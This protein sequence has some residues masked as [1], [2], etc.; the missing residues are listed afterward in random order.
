[1]RILS[2]AALA[3]GSCVL[4]TDAG[5]RQVDNRIGRD[6]QYTFSNMDAHEGTP[7]DVVLVEK[8]QPPPIGPMDKLLRLRSHARIVLPPRSKTGAPY[9]DEVLTLRNAM[10]VPVAELLFYADTNNND[11][12][13]YGIANGSNPNGEHIWR[14]P[15][16]ESGIGEFAH[17][18]NFT[19]FQKSEYSLMLGNVVLQIDTPREWTPA[20]CPGGEDHTLEVRVVI[21]PGTE[22][23]EIGYYKN[24]GS[25]PTPST[26]IV[27]ED[28]VDA[29][30]EY[31][32]DV[33]IDGAVARAIKVLA[34][35]AGNL[36]IAQGVW[37]PA[38]SE[39]K[40]TVCK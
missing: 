40:A 21:S 15:V 9:P 1:M 14:E 28:T 37:F 2:I 32:F 18:T 35:P 6:L 27:L 17:S 36:N 22:A 3:L 10:K 38:A 8:I 25:N 5:D 34:P 39:A 31:E 29:G 16:A 33:L 26:S 13:E 12:I 30:S 20:P 4:A 23:R 11:K 19:D 24:Y 7:L